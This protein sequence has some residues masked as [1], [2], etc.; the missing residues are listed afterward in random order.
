MMHFFQNKKPLKICLIV[1]AIFFIFAIISNFSVSDSGSS[2][3][4]KKSTSEKEAKE[5]ATDSDTLTDSDESVEDTGSTDFSNC[6]LLTTDDFLTQESNLYNCNVQVY[7]KYIFAGDMYMMNSSYGGSYVCISYDKDLHD[8]ENNI[9]AKEDATE[10]Y[11]IVQGVYSGVDAN[12]DKVIKASDITLI[13][14]ETYNSMYARSEVQERLDSE[15]YRSV[16]A[17]VLLANPSA[18]ENRSILV[19]SKYQQCPDERDYY[20]LLQ[21]DTSENNI[22]V[23]FYKNLA[24]LPMFDYATN[25]LIANPNEADDSGYMMVY[26]QLSDD[27]LHSKYAITA[28]AVFFLTEDEYN[29][30]VTDSDSDSEGGY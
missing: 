13:S 5:K 11:M 2:T 12:S 7:G 21:N 4:K 18:F 26:G 29:N 30:F 24:Y 6:P 10:G 25:T 27:F 23:G 20:F 1:V 22:Y 15:T 3:S 19:Y 28:T 17:D 9:I 16:S 8:S 14:L